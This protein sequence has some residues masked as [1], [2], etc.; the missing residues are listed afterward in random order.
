MDLQSGMSFDSGTVSISG[1]NTDTETEPGTLGESQE[2]AFLARH[3]VSDRL[4]SLLK[5][6]PQIASTHPAAPAA[7]ASAL[8]AVL[9]RYFPHVQIY[10]EGNAAALQRKPPSRGLDVQSWNPNQIDP[11]LRTLFGDDFGLL[12]ILTLLDP[13]PDMLPLTTLGFTH[14]TLAATLDLSAGYSFTAGS[15]E[16]GFFT[17]AYAPGERP[18][19]WQVLS[20]HISLRTSSAAKSGMGAALFKNWVQAHYDN[21]Q[22]GA[23]D[24][25]ASN[26]GRYAWRSLDLPFT[27]QTRQN[28]YRKLKEFL[29]RWNFPTNELSLRQAQT[30]LRVS[31]MLRVE[32]PPPNF[33]RFVQSLECMNLG[34]GGIKPFFTP[35][36]ARQIAHYPGIIFLVSQPLYE[37][38]WNQ[39]FKDRFPQHRL[40]G[41]LK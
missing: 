28:I 1:A 13:A 32:N 12:S 6:R 40:F 20:P 8:D 2:E 16:Q 36:K 41:D 19:T 10:G 22:I 27:I 35:E 17:A 39:N 31:R 5:N 4:A 33:I 25:T 9:G 24:I 18:G 29:M 21:P 38:A 37:V 23:M 11:L 14:G 30:P 26:V 34:N 3:A 7:K 15:R